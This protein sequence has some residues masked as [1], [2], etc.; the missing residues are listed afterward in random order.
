M[1]RKD[2]TFIGG[3]HGSFESTQW[4][5]I[6]LA[7]GGE[8]G[9]RKKAVARILGQYWK[10]VYCYLRRKGYDNEK[11]K[12]LTQGYFCDIVL[13]RKLLERADPRKG[14]FRTL[15]LTALN[16]YAISVARREQ[17]GK[18]KPA[19]GLIAL[20][21][22]DAPVPEPRDDVTP[23]EAFQCAWAAALVEAVL[24]EVERGCLADGRQRHWRV[25]HALV[26]QPILGEGAPVPLAELCETLGIDS[27]T[28]AY[29]MNVTVKRRFQA[30]ME[31]RVRQYTDSDAAVQEEIR[32]IMA[33]LSRRPAG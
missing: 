4:T 33:A 17:A 18:R 30:A 14:K 22:D 21:G 2:H 8:E 27:T 10:P 16:N 19:E 31:A 13:G 25:F 6:F 1:A 28:K 11:A 20:D 7:G 15:L 32:D 24:E 23:Q 29:N 3:E 5:Q 12:D 26:V 9:P